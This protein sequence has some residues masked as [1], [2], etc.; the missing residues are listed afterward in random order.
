MRLSTLSSHHFLLL[1]WYDLHPSDKDVY[2]EPGLPALM[3]QDPSSQ[4][5]KGAACEPRQSLQH[6]LLDGEQ[7]P[8]L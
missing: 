5:A 8:Q 4:R 6:A 7:D 1:Q 2:R 3:A